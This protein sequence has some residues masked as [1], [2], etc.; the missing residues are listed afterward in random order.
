MLVG[1]GNTDRIWVNDARVHEQLTPRTAVPDQDKVD[2]ELKEGWN[3]VLAKVVKTNSNQSLYLRF[4]GEGLRVSSQPN[5]AE[6][7]LPPK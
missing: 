4:T 5:A 2:V 7:P 1:A 3:T 6:V